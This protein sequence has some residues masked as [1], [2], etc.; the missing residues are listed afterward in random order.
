[1]KYREQ[2]FQLKEDEHRRKEREREEKEKY[3]ECRLEALR[4]Q[5]SISTVAYGI[6][7]S[8]GAVAYGIIVSIGA[9]LH[10]TTSQHSKPIPACDPDYIHLNCFP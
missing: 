6:I 2:E 8:I 7:V 5:A 4:E 9:V 10:G 3:K 1:M